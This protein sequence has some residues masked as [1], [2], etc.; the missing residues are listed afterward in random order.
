MDQLLGVNEPLGELL[1][2][3]PRKRQA[4]RGRRHRDGDGDDVGSDDSWEGEGREMDGRRPPMRYMDDEYRNPTPYRGMANPPRGGMNPPRGFRGNRGRGG[5]NQFQ[6]RQGP[7][8]PFEQVNRS[9]VWGGGIKGRFLFLTRLVFTITFVFLLLLPKSSSPLS[10]LPMVQWNLL[11]L[12]RRPYKKYVV[13]IQYC[14][15]ICQAAFAH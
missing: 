1:P 6:G 10:S 5:Y 12:G 2:E 4:K 8:P 11:A 15:A 14:G 3:E 13:F 7:R 9:L